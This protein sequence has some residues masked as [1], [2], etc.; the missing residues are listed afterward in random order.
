MLYKFDSKNFCRTLYTFSR[1]K[2]K[3]WVTRRV[4]PVKRH[5][6]IMQVIVGEFREFTNIKTKPTGCEC[7]CRAA[8]KSLWCARG[9]GGREE[10]S[11]GVAAINIFL[12]M[13]KNA[14][15]VSTPLRNSREFAQVPGVCGVLVRWLHFTTS[16]A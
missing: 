4:T 16:L 3:Y 13:L 10:A 5:V 15:V 11:L 9:G 7:C 8:L 1:V 2:I 6:V 14:E 12:R